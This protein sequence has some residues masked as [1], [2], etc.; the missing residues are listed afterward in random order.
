ML[1]ECVEAV[2]F[3]PTSPWYVGDWGRRIWKYTLA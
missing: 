1:G 3:V 2:Q